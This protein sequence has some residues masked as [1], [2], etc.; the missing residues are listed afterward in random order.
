MTHK[1]VS[2]VHKLAITFALAAIIGLVSISNASAQSTS[3]SGITT[4]PVSVNLT[5]K[6]GTTTTTTLQVINDG[7]KTIKVKIK[8]AKFG[9]TGLTGRPAIFSSTVGDPSIDWVSFS[10]TE[11]TAIPGVWQP[12]TMTINVPSSATLGYYYAVLFE[13]E[14]SVVNQKNTNIIVGANAS[15]VLLDTN[16]SNEHRQID[17]MSFISEKKV[18]DFLPATFSY[19]IKNSGNIH[20]IPTGDIY[21]TRTP[22]GKSIDVIPVNSGQGNI[23]PNS[24]RTYTEQWTDGFPA[25]GLKKINGQIVSDSNGKPIKQ[26]QW[27]FSRPLSKFRFGKYYAHLVLVYN[28]GN[29][30]VPVNA[31]VSFWVIPWSLILLFILFIT[32]WILLPRLI[33]KLWKK[34]SANKPKND[35]KKEAK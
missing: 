31:I 35:S 34:R 3:G 18:Y 20:V 32:A 24:V 16:S 22:N 10:T 33:R 6:P 19:T 9:A 1:K 11:V 30:D 17:V 26:L 28:N 7:T 5:A 8:L 27:D 13:P 21:I 4:S 25:Y 2:G 12:V 15:L 14:I 23:L 29:R